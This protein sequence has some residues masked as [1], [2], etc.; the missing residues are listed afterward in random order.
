MHSI[1]KK[2]VKI[3]G[4]MNVSFFHDDYMKYGDHIDEFLVGFWVNLKEADPKKRPKSL[5]IISLL[6]Y[7]QIFRQSDHNIILH[8]FHAP[9]IRIGRY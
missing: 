8:T 6:I 1:I 5:N 2:C 3:F 4:Y 9:R 7:I